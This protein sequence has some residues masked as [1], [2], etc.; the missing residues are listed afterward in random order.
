VRFICSESARISAQTLRL[1]PGHLWE[2]GLVH[3]LG[4]RGCCRLCG[5][6]CSTN[7]GP[8]IE[9]LQRMTTEQR[10]LDPAAIPAT[11]EELEAFK[12]AAAR[13][14]IESPRRSVGAHAAYPRF[15]LEIRDA[16]DEMSQCTVGKGLDYNL[17]IICQRTRGYLALDWSEL[18]QP[19]W[20]FTNSNDLVPA[21][22]HS[23]KGQSTLGPDLVSLLIYWATQRASPH[24]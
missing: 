13:V 2:A 14:E 3:P 19:L 20:E 22:L 11:P 6:D 24:L 16:D 15:R 1:Q 4:S 8:V 21:V 12:S 5:V 10:D 9:F 17:G 23:L 18:C 7:P